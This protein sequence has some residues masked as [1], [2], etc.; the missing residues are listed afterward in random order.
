[1]ILTEYYQLKLTPEQIS[2]SVKSNDGRMIIKNVLLQEAEKFNRNKRKY[3]RPVLE[4]EINKY[5]DTLVK[6]NRALGELDHSDKNVVNLQNA[7]L[8]INEIYWSN[9][10]VRGDIEILD[11]AEFPAGR[12]LGGLLRRGIPVGISS[13]G[14]GSTLELDEEGHVEVGEDYN[15]LCFDA[16]SFESTIGSNFSL[17]EGAEATKQ[18]N[19]WKKIDDLIYEILCNNSGYCECST[20][21]K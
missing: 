11:S 4:R 14:Y 16:V 1:M 7:C 21:K 18:I 3:P 2:E 10:E 5:N 12:I 8:K 9:N 6:S 17:N 20:G 13:R 15:L 19:K